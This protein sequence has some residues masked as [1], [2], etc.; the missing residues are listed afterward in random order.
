MAWAIAAVGFMLLIVFH[1]LGHFAAAKAVGM[2]VE[3]FSLF[4]GQM[5]A[6]TTRGETTYGIGWIPLGGYVKISGMNPHEALPEGEEHR[7]YYKQPVWKRIFVISAGPAVNLIIAFVLLFGLF[8]I[9][10]T[11]AGEGTRVVE[12][13]ENNS[14]ADGVLEP[15]DRI[16]SVDGV[17]ELAR[18]PVQISSH[19]CAGEPSFNCRAETPAVIRF[20][21]DGEIR[22]AEVYPRYDTQGERTRVGFAFAPSDYEPMPVGEAFTWAGDRMWFA[23]SESAKAI[24]KIVYDSDAR[25]NVSGVVGSYDETRHSFNMPIYDAV[26]ILALISLSLAVINLVPFLPLDGGHIFWALAEK[27]RGRPISFAVMEK[28]GLVGFALV[29]ILFVIGLNNDIGRLTNEGFHTR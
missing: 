28:A 2:R 11:P 4:F 12:R 16:L 29:A 5:W 13:T 14:P 8:A 3:K 9:H 26:L 27:V 22:T 25:K 18:L 7:A 24:V 20:E 19:Q 15:G 6:K 17:T 10:G 1:E 23:V 21:R